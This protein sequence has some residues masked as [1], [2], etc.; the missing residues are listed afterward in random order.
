MI[1]TRS[2]TFTTLQAIERDQHMSLGKHS[3]LPI[4]LILAFSAFWGFACTR[5][6]A[7]CGEKAGTNLVCVHYRQTFCSNPWGAALAGDTL[8]EVIRERYDS[9]GVTLYRLRSHQK[10]PDLSFPI[11]CESRSGTVVC[12]SVEDGD[13]LKLL[14]KDGFKEG[15][16]C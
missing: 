1:P 6:K 5:E 14:K 13:G 9:M 16:E 2:P 8:L 12:G 15:K 10:Q 4:F 11:D 7:A 3:S